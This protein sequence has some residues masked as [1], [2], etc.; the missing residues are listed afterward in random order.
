MDSL[1]FTKVIIVVVLAVCLYMFVE[2]EY[3][4]DVIF[5]KSTINNQSYLVRN[6]R[7]A[8]QASNML[9][10]ISMRL[11]DVVSSLYK[12]YPNDARVKR[13][14]R[15]YNPHNVSE[16]APNSTYTS[17]SVNKGEKIVFCLRSK[18]ERQE[19]HDFNTITFVALHELA[20]LMTE[21]VGHTPEFW[22]NFRFILKHAADNGF[23]QRQNFRE[24]PVKY[25]GT[26]ITDSP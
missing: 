8:P 1:F 16:S 19:L 21:S 10:Q 7:D 11:M 5:V 22:D 20:H 25:C 2:S 26:M 9:A 23:Y 17:Y 6:V 15:R 13:L 4:N 3:V 12:A 18:D 14:H 24:N